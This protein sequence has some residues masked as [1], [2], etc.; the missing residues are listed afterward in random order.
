MKKNN[1]HTP[2]RTLANIQTQPGRRTC[3]SVAR[4]DPEINWAHPARRQIFRAI[5]KQTLFSFGKTKHPEAPSPRT[6][7]NN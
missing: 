3:A 6:K 1:G 4:K 5:R 7:K 2:Y